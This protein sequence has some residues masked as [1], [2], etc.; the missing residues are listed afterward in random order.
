[1][2]GI[3]IFKQIFCYAIQFLF[4]FFQK[5]DLTIQKQWGLGLKLFKPWLGANQDRKFR[6]YERKYDF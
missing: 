4:P 2:R 6:I 3:F 1:M 5:R